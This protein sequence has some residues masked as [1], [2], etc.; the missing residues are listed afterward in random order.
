MVVTAI[1][2]LL[3]GLVLFLYGVMLMGDGLNQ[4]AGGRL[5]AVL[6]RLTSHPLKGIALGAAVTAVIQSSTA[7][8]IIAIG[9]ISS[10]MMSLR[11]AASII[12]GSIL[13]TSVTGWIVSLSFMDG[14]GS[15]MMSWLTVANLTAVLA[16][17]GI[18]L[19][20]FQKT[21]MKNS[22]GTILLG[23]TI[24][25]T[26]MDIMS[27]AVSPLKENEAFISLLTNFSNPVVGILVGM[28]F[29]AIIQS[30]AAAIGILQALSVTGAITFSA[31]FPIVLGVA[32]GGAIPVLLS[33]LGA[34]INAR[35]TALMHL[36]MDILGAVLCGILF[37]VIH[38]VVSFGFYNM[39]MNAVN[40]ALINTLF[41]LVTVVLLTPAIGLLEKIVRR[42]VPEPA[43]AP[44]EA[45]AIGVLLEDRFLAYPALALSQCHMAIGDMAACASEGIAQ[46]KKLLHDFNEH[47][48]SKVEQ[49]ETRC[50]LYE[51]RV[52]T[53][54]MK[55][56]RRELNEAEN[57]DVTLYLHALSDFE[58]ISDH[59]MNI[60]HTARQ[61]S[62][63]N[64]SYSPDARR[65]L[66]VMEQA[67]DAIADKARATFD[68]KDLAAAQHT[69]SL[70]AV[71]ENLCEAMRRHH[72]ERMRAGICTPE[73]GVTFNDLIS[74]YEEISERCKKLAYM[75][76]ELA[77]NGADAH[78][79]HQRL[80]PYET[81]EYAHYSRQ[82][83]I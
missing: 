28:V 51:D 46:V 36:V 35:R 40:I 82:F 38:A 18:Y 55:A 30:S 56:T 21:P 54:L 24:L 57:R 66:G 41:R 44:A 23:F 37:Y 60:A 8:S 62:Q 4:V 43:Q 9:F 26:G 10:G 71:I 52:G 73:Q 67:V 6:Y 2:S 64:I 48:F 27:A 31:A 14:G 78:A 61:M 29:T 49:L 19:R 79:Y 50:D 76:L 5:E 58:R 11:Q 25:M 20:K 39:P 7:T 80:S 34:D 59:A 68:D 12:L 70:A 22:V 42:I 15:G 65:E 13:G 33:A 1:L 69:V 72:I 75:I 45:D 16:C 32:V 77:E 47:G 81:E 3:C 53:Y 17:A 74:N 63:K 83:A